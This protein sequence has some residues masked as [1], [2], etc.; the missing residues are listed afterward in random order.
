MLFDPTLFLAQS[1]GPVMQYVDKL[2]RTPLSQILILVAICTVIRM[3]LFPK[4]TQTAKHLRF[5]GGYSTVKILSDTCDAIIYAGVIVFL[6]IRPF[7]VQTFFIPSPSMETTL[8]TSDYIIA[9]KFIYRFQEPQA[10]DIT[11][12]R[13]P[14]RAIPPGKPQEDY[15]KR[16]VGTPGQIIEMRD[17]Y[18]YRDGKE[19]NEPYVKNGKSRVDFKLVNDNGRYI[20]CVIY[21]GGMINVDNMAPEYLED[22]NDLA[23][24]EHLKNLPPVAVPPGQ[25]LMVGDNR[26]ASFDGRF[27]G[28]VERRSLIGK[29]EFIWLPFSRMGR[30]Q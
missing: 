27:W 12:F 26:N 4:L 7:A 8:M 13:P 20:P 23:R 2:A 19:V 3:A 15:I 30:P 29:A 1:P 25:L 9:N 17:G 21:P 11:V 10:G 16:C 22:P 14:M 24:Q 28:L 18:L 6:I 5:G